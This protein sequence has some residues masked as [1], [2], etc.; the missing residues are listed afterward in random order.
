MNELG[1]TREAAEALAGTVPRDAGWDS[2]QWSLVH[3]GTSL[4]VKDIRYSAPFYRRTAGRLILAH[5]ERIYRRTEGL[6]FVP[7]CYGRLDPWSLLFERVDATPLTRVNPRDLPEGFYRQVL[8]C[9]EQLHGRGIVHL[10]LRHM[11]NI[12]VTPSGRPVLIDF[13]SSLFL[14]RGPFSRK[15]L[16]PLL[17]W[18]DF[19]GILK[20]LLRDFPDQVSEEDRKRYERYRRLHVLWPFHRIARKIRHR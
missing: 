8:S 14:G 17:S 7:K 2:S 15:T 16:V 13:E 6:P 1:L 20:F 10:D 19:S 9:L 11:G 3:A 5:E 18:I 4:L 12:L